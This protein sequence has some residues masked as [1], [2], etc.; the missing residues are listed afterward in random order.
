[1]NTRAEA[2]FIFRRVRWCFPLRF[3]CR[4]DLRR[5]ADVIAARRCD[6]YLSTFLAE[7]EIGEGEV[8]Y[9]HIKKREEQKESGKPATQAARLQQI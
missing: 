8:Y 9:D 7:L 3:A 1:M 4:R 2:I 5:S 6:N